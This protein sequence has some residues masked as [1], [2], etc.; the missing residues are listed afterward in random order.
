MSTNNGFMSKSAS[1]VLDCYSIIS[2]VSDDENTFRARCDAVAHLSE[3]SL[4][5][6][7][8]LSLFSSVYPSFS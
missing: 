5:L 1:I 4:Q 7:L 8:K 6:C 2:Y 3:L